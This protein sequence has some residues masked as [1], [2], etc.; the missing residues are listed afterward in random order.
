ML[1]NSFEKL[2]D[3]ALGRPVGKADLAAML[4]DTN[5]FARSAILARG[6]HHAEGRHNNVE[7]GVGEGEGLR[8]SSKEFDV[9]PFGLGSFAGA[10]EKGRHIVRGGYVAPTAGGGDR[11]IAVASCHIEDLLARAQVEGFAKLF[12]NDL[13]RGADD[14]VIAG[15]PSPVLT[16]LDSVE[17]DR[18]SRI[19]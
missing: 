1:T 8:V 6:E 14:G 16:S 13:E 9:E 3:E 11:G 7:R 15:R 18:R 5:K 17:V 4:A 2:A 12:A 10:L 19:A